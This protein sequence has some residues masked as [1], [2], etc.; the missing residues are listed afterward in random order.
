MPKDIDP[1]H[2]LEIFS[3]IYQ[4]MQH[5]HAQM[6]MGTMDD[7]I[8][9]PESGEEVYYGDLL[10]GLDTL[11]DRERQVFELVHLQGYTQIAAAKLVPHI[12]GHPVSEASRAAL[13]HMVRCYDR[14]EGVI[15]EQEKAVE[16]MVE[17]LHPIVA[18]KLRE[19][20]DE[21]VA[22]RDEAARRAEEMGREIGRVEAMLSGVGVPELV[23]S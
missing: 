23:S 16:V 2:R 1:Q 6:E 3:R 8:T 11:P 4:Y 17:Q 21:L 18:G 15:E 12:P 19:A 14:A 22:A 9:I 7:I 5:W 20:L 10:V 13:V